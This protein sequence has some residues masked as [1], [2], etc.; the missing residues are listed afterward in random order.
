MLPSTVMV[1]LRSSASNRALEEQ[2][3][4]VCSDINNFN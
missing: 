2:K 1:Q 4:L 3:A